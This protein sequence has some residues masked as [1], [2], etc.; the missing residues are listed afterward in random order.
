MPRIIIG[1]VRIDYR[2]IE[3]T[4]SRR[5]LRK[6]HWVEGPTR[7]CSRDFRSPNRLKPKAPIAGTSSFGQQEMIP[8]LRALRQRANTPRAAATILQMPPP[9]VLATHRAS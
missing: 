7:C 5:A 9:L 8:K 1:F 6:L 3:A 2:E 4:T